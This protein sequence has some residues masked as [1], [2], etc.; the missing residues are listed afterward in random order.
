MKKQSKRPKTQQ[1]TFSMAAIQPLTKTQ[2]DTFQAYSA[3]KNLMLHGIAGTGKTFISLYLALTEILK[4]NSSYNRVVI[5]RSVVPS[6]DMGFLP[7]NISEKARIYEE[8]YHEICNEL[9]DR[10]DAYDILKNKRL[11]QFVT[12][13]HLRG[14]TFHDAI[15]LVDETENMSGSELDTVITRIGRNS[16]L[17]FCGDYRQSDLNM[18]ER[19]GFKRFM[20]IIGYMESFKFIE[21]G[22]DD[23]VRS[24]LVKEYLTHKYNMGVAF[25]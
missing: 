18:H 9:F 1:Q 19:E 20:N 2:K 13:S 8:P 12:T 21:F 11:V 14:T 16:K 24:A 10:G 7:G 22:I 5:V 25:V 6:R 15:V 3:G 4:G 17:I 23:I